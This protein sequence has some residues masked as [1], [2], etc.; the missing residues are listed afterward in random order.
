MFEVLPLPISYKGVNKSRKREEREAEM[1]VLPSFLLSP[2]S[3]MHP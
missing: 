3:S 2:T 1:G